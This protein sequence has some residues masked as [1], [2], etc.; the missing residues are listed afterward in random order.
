MAPGENGKNIYFC[1]IASIA[2]LVGHLTNDPN[3]EGS[4]LGAAGNW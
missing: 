1:R 3:F 2:L 4:N